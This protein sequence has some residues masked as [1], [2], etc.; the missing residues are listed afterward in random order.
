M[1][2]ETSV[3][4]ASAIRPGSL[5]GFDVAGVRVAVANADGRY[6]AFDE[7]CTHEQCSLVDEGVL[8]G[9]VLT[10]GCHGAQFDITTGEV[11]SPPA[12]DPLKVYRVRVDGDDLIVE[13]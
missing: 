4:K 8:E 3:G 6:F 5:A 10:C 7:H 9:T 13:V 2:S 1:G 11:L 12:P